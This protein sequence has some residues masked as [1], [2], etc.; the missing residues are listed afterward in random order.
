MH[1]EF[2]LGGIGEFRGAEDFQTEGRNEGNHEETHEDCNEKT[3]AGS[4]FRYPLL[5]Q[6][7][8]ISICHGSLSIVDH[9]FWQSTESEAERGNSCGS[10]S[11][12]LLEGAE[13]RGD[14]RYEAEEG[15]P[16]GANRKMVGNRGLEPLTSW[17]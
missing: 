14:G 5:P 9:H 13:G 4:H 1:V 11:L 7:H 8:R 12:N 16:S 2:T 3:M 15:F 6:L 10:S 17:V